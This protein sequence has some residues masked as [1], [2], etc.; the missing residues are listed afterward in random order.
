MENKFLEDYNSI[1]HSRDELEIFEKCVNSYQG[2]S[3]LEFLKFLRNEFS[4]SEVNDFF[5][6]LVDGADELDKKKMDEL[7]MKYDRICKLKLVI[8]DYINKDNV[9]AKKDSS[10][11]NRRAI[12]NSCNEDKRDFILMELHKKLNN[13]YV[14]TS[15]ENFKNLFK[16]VEYNPI[17]WLGTDAELK[18]LIELL[19]RKL[20]FNFGRNVNIEI[21]AR[22]FKE[23]G[24]PYNLNSLRKATGSASYKQII[25]NDPANEIYLIIQEIK[26]LAYKI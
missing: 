16:S 7:Q 21:V 10:V 19:I 15:Y 13:R 24:V 1:A 12:Q 9:E 4:H 3:R 18:A 6:F 5:N 11:K 20:G 2:E 25:S 8:D 14:I 22:F 23:E 17:K 26:E